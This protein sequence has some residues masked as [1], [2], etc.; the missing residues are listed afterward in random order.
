MMPLKH[1]LRECTAEFKLSKLQEKINQL[2][3]IDDIKLFAKNEKELETLIQAKRI[4]NQDKR[5]GFS[6]EKCAILVM[7]GGIRHMTDEIELP[8]QEKI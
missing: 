6:I 1:I 4:Y 2:M 5:I 3:Y 8:N 7:E